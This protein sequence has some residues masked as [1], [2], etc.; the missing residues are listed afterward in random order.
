MS[1]LD[2][3]FDANKTTRSIPCEIRYTPNLRIA[4]QDCQPEIYRVKVDPARKCVRAYTRHGDT[5][6]VYDCS[7]RE[8]STAYAIAEIL[9][10]LGCYPP[11]SIDIPGYLTGGNVAYWL[12]LS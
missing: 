7:R 4:A 5:V 12:D 8:G 10:G 1:A 11:P 3:F 6:Y 2:A 9:I